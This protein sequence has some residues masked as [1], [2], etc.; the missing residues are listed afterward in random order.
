MKYIMPY[1]MGSASAKALARACSILRI[2]GDKRLPSQSLIVNWG[3]TKT[4]PKLLN[5]KVINKPSSV[6][7]AI[8]KAKALPVMSSAGVSTVEHTASKDVVNGWIESGHTVFART[9]A[10]SSQ[11]KGIVILDYNS[12]DIPYA[13][14]YTKY[15]PKCH[16]YRVHVFGG[17]VIDFI[18]KKRSQS[19][20]TSDF[21]RNHSNGWIFCRQDV[22]LPL[23]VIEQATKAV[24]ALGLDFGAVDILYK[25]KVNTA[26]V[27]EVNTAPG[28][29]ASTLDKYKEAIL[30]IR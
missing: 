25:E 26:W 18:K 30:E 4:T 23:V 11:G 1:K 9:L 24:A 7:I 27:L 28:I 15:I 29:E 10:S 5:V 6:S 19:G 20:T 14:I 2:R 3:S 12:S 13:S 22:V 21:I 8:N 16:E 17:K